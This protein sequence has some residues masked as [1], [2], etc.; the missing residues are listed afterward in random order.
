MR[1]LEQSLSKSEW[2]ELLSWLPPDLDTMARQTGAL[3]RPRKVETGELLL[4]LVLAYSVLDLS[5]RGVSSWLAQQGLAKISD[6][7]VLKRL[8]R[9][10]PFMEQVLAWLLS[11]TLQVLPQ[12]GLSYRVVLG[13]A[14]ALRSP[15]GTTTDWRVH[16]GYDVAHCCIS[17]VE[18][19]DVHGAENLLRLGAGPGDLVVGDRNYAKT[20][21]V[22]AVRRAGA[23]LL[24]RTGYRSLTLYDAQNQR[25]RP[26]DWATRR[27]ARRGRPERI[28]ECPVW[29]KADEHSVHARLIVVRRSRAAAEQERLRKQA[30]A[31]DGQEAIATNASGRGVHLLVDHCAAG[32]GFRRA[33][34]RALPDPMAGG[35][36]VQ[37]AE[38]AAAPR[39]APRARTR[40]RLLLPVREA[41]CC[42]PPAAHRQPAGGFFPLGTPHRADPCRLSAPGAG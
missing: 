4:R 27:R 22:V 8:R 30:S 32:G 41:H 34:G 36:A 29:L 16:V 7:A 9:A 17:R 11:Q 2:Q 10:V 31:E 38:V 35:A 25:L 42:R 15:G 14:T 39:C 1:S 18:L 13:D 40:G 6:V 3:R 33:A 12:S 26:L 5:M 23:H 24:I 37:A 28:E 21:K 20:Q 19:T